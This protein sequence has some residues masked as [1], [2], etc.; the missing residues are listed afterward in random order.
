MRD[1]P[2]LLALIIT[3]T[4]WMPSTFVLFSIVEG[5]GSKLPYW[6]DIILAPGYILG[7]FLGF[8]GGNTYAFLG[9]LISFIIIFFIVRAFTTAWKNK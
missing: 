7:F 4:Y 8:G 3:L 1:K 9:Q 6:L 2:N 5:S